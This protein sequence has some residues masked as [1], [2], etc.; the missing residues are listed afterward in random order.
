MPVLQ[1]FS[2]VSFLLSVKFPFQEH[3]RIS[4]VRLGYVLRGS[5]CQYLSSAPSSVRSKVNDVVC[6]LYH[7]K[8]VLDD[9]YGIA[10]VH[11][12]LYDVHENSYI[13]EMQS[14]G[15]LVEYVERFPR[16]FFAQFGGEFHSLAFTA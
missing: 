14:C 12:L 15:R 8:I 6:K 1:Y 16:V 13:L 10:F 9:D 5:R 4:L 2:A 11:E 3:W 7:V